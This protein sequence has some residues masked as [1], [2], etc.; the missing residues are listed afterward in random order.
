MSP[1][2][3]K[4]LTQKPINAQKFHRLLHRPPTAVPFL[5]TDSTFSRLAAL[6]TKPK[7]TTLFKCIFFTMQVFHQKRQVDRCQ[8]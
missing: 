5:L 8:N 6:K 4:S 7:G 3:V 1:A 2:R